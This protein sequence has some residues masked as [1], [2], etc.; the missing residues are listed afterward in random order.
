MKDHVIRCIERLV[1]VGNSNEDHRREWVSSV[2]ESL[3][4]GCRILDAGAGEQQFRKFCN[5]LRYVSQDLSAY[6][7]NG[8]E[9]GLQTGTWDTT[10]IDIVS[11]ICSIP[12]PDGSFDA[13]LCTEVLEHLPEPLSALREFA[14]L[15]RKGGELI[16][17]APFCSL[18]HFAPAHFCTGFSRYFFELHLPKLGFQITQMEFNG[19]FWEYLAQEIRRIRWVKGRY[20]AGKL[21]ILDWLLMYFMLRTLSKLNKADIGSHDILCYGLHLRALKV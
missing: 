5:H 6:D 13:V 19:N 16:I 17:T 21:H 3:S 2:L 9:C 18:T 15:L 14:R 12:E 7:G 1:P 10:D 11:D 4:P 8:N 20:T